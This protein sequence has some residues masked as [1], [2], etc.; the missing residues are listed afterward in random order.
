MSVHSWKQGDWAVF[1]LD[2]VQIKELRGGNCAT[3]SEGSFETSGMLLNRL[4]PLTLRNK[5]T[6]E[7]FDWHYNELRKLRG[8]AGF[9][10]PDIS[11]LFCSLALQAM[12]NEEVDKAAYDKATDFL[13]QA[14]DYTPVIHGIHLF[15]GR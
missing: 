8:E 12:D 1:D 13:A 2:I 14:K 3:V 9:N 6:I 15:R 10:Y 5:R 7:W 11:R 4:R